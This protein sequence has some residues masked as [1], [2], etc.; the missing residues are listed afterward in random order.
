MN[1]IM[2]N[3]TV[4]NP[5]LFK[6]A[7]P[8]S[9]P[10]GPVEFALSKEDARWVELVRQRGE[11]F[12]L[13]APASTFPSRDFW[14][15]LIAQIACDLA[16]RLRGQ[17]GS[18]A[19]RVEILS[20]NAAWNEALGKMGKG[21]SAPARILSAPSLVTAAWLV[22][23][24]LGLVTAHSELSALAGWLGKPQLLLYP[25]HVEQFVAGPRGPFA[26]HLDNGQTLHGH[27]D[28]YPKE[29]QSWLNQFFQLMGLNR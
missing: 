23:Q 17:G 4:P 20:P 6:A 9:V 8:S 27:W 16:A 28:R 19:A 10:P 12:V 26:S 2:L 5:E 3:G 7:L 25:T 22:Q 29:K 21:P 14:G 11:S 15:D 24:S 1:C 13:I 18:A